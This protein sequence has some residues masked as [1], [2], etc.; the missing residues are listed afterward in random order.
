[1]G[2]AGKR[3]N[4]GTLHMQTRLGTIRSIDGEGR[5]EMTFTGSLLVSKLDGDL[6]VTGNVRK[7]FDRKGR[8]CYTGT[9]KMVAEGK[10]RTIHWF[11]RDMKAVWYGKGMANISGEFSRDPKTGKLVTGDYWYNDPT[12]KQAFP[13]AALQPVVL[14]K[15]TNSSRPA[16]E[17][18]IRRKK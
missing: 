5:F 11:G 7:E 9:G 8:V 2:K 4:Y 13:N 1:M 17:P 6:K 14:P 15:R 3:T 12:Q 10:W 16:E 18:T